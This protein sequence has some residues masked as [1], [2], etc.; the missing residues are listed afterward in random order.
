MIMMNNML[1]PAL[2]LLVV[3]T[4]LISASCGARQ[5][6]RGQ[7]TSGLDRK[8]ST[9][10]FI[11]EGEIVTFIIGT[12]ATRYRENSNYIPL[13]ITIANNG[14]RKLTLTRESFVLIDEEGNRYPAANPREL[15]ERYEFLDLDRQ[16]L[17]ELGDIV[18]NKFAAYTRYGSKF[19]P[20]HQAS[21]GRSNLVRD[22]VSLPKFG[23]IIDFL[24]FPKPSTGLK[25]HRFE[26]FMESPDLAEPV[27]V[28][29]I[30]E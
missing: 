21:T 9:Y 19:S 28:K 1:K 17:A 20:T 14:L 11:E 6:I 26:L 3:A 7:E 4:A 8:L 24:Y 12:R 16:S 13:E 15:M 27:F 23:Y 25:G 5:P 18:F 22:M 30:V 29:F 10:A 2:V